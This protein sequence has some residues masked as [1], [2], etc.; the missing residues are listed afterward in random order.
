MV[1][2]HE[3]SFK[4]FTYNTLC[5]CQTFITVQSRK[6]VGQIN[7]KL[8]D[9]CDVRTSEPI[10]MVIDEVRHFACLLVFFILLLP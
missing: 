9:H 7:K 4:V 1:I 3:Y 6:H 2:V 10:R 8:C 5:Q